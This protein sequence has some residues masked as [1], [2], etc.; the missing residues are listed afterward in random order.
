MIS[1]C[2]CF[3]SGQQSCFTGTMVGTIFWRVF[4]NDGIPSANL[5]FFKLNALVNHDFAGCWYLNF[6]KHTR[7]SCLYILSYGCIIYR[8]YI[9]L[10]MYLTQF[11]GDWLDDLFP[12]LLR[13]EISIWIWAMYV[14]M[15][16][17]TC[18][19]MHTTCIYIYIHIPDTQYIYSIYVIY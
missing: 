2:R 6:R 1:F 5:L 11:Y 12:K 7:V 14:Y 9:Y 16:T 18:M 8:S 15:N 13:G 17:W 4:R 10:Y 3:T 19:Y